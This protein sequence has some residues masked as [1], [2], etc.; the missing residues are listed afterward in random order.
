MISN[1][2]K[3]LRPR[4]NLASRSFVTRTFCSQIDFEERDNIEMEDYNRQFEMDDYYLKLTDEWRIPL[5][6]KRLRQERIR[7]IRENM[8]EPEEQEPKF[9]AH[10]PFIPLNLPVRPENQFAIVSMNGTQHKVDNF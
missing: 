6:K 1:C 9:I 4:I 8:V 10:N 2:I 5:E 7:K 3:A